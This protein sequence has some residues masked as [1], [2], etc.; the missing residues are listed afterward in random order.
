VAPTVVTNDASGITASGATLNGNVTSDG[1]ATVTARGFAYGTSANPTTAGST[2]PAGDG[3]GTFTAAIS[4]LTAGA[5]YHVRAYAI[6]SEG[7]S[8]GTDREFTTLTG[9][10]GGDPS[11]VKPTVATNAA[12]GVTTSGATLNGNVT[13]SGGA[14]VTARGFVYGLSADPA[15]GGA[16]VTQAASGGGT[17]TFTAAISGLSAS[18]TYHVRAYATNSAGTA[19][20]SDV[21][22][23]TSSGGGSDPDDPYIFR[24]LTDSATGIIVSGYIHRDAALT[25]KNTVLHA[26]GTC[27]AC[28]AIRARMTDSDFITLA[29][30]D[31]SLSLGFTG[32]LTVTIP[33][34]AQYNGETVTILHCANGTLKTYTAT[35]QDGKATFTVTSLSPFAVFAD[36]DELDNIPKTG[37]GGGFPLWLGLMSLGTLGGCLWLLLRRRPKRA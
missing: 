18:T 35:V 27:A 4:G 21:T 13:A 30:K 31:I 7:T 33:V 34:G 29:D 32:S 14:T 19:Y 20:G 16:G 24:T 5:T 26:A 25:V 23:T 17:G 3:T 6:N 11:P 12:S 28:D 8:Y 1:G 22:F 37:D 36:A 10:G 2:A 9:G 15:I